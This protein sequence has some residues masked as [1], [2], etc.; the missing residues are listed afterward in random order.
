MN[1]LCEFRLGCNSQL[2][3]ERYETFTFEACKVYL[4]LSFH[5]VSD[6]NVICVSDCKVGHD[7]AR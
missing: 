2:K 1:M 7:D 5:E 4:A 3:S 6:N